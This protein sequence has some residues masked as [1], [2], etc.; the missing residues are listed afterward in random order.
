MLCMWFCEIIDNCLGFCLFEGCEIKI[1]VI[2]IV[3]SCVYV[4]F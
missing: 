1:Y 3:V 2:S 4:I